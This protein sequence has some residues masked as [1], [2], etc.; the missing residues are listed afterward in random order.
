MTSTINLTLKFI[1]NE[2]LSETG[3]VD[4]VGANHPKN[5]PKVDFWVNDNTSYQT[6]DAIKDTSDLSGRTWIASLVIQNS[7]APWNDNTS[8]AGD[9]ISYKIYEYWDLAKDAN[10]AC[11]KCLQQL[12]GGPSRRSQKVQGRRF[13]KI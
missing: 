11:A 10:F 13:Y 2:R 3:G 5:S 9:N 1:A 4:A 8:A 6:V 12:A 7:Q